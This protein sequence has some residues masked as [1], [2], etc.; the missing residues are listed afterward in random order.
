MRSLLRSYH[1]GHS[2]RIS[3]LEAFGPKCRATMLHK[4]SPLVTVTSRCPSVDCLWPAAMT[5]E[6]C[7]AGTPCIVSRSFFSWD[8]CGF[9]DAEDSAATEGVVGELGAVGDAEAVGEGE[10]VA[11]MVNEWLTNAG[12]GTSTVC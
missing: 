5:L 10:G 7:C 4:E 6:R 8:D 2:A 3:V 1:F 9:F 11:S 12:L